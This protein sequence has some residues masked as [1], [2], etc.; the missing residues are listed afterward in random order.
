MRCCVHVVSKP[1]FVLSFL[2]AVWLVTM[3]L[4]A[5]TLTLLL[6]HAQWQ[7]MYYMLAVVA[8]LVVFPTWRCISQSYKRR[9]DGPW[10]LPTNLLLSSASRSSS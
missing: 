6:D 8:L 1:A 2:V 3:A 9:L 5:A 7:A 4:I 10:S